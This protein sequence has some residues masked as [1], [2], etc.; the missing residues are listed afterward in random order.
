MKCSPRLSQFGEPLDMA[1][2]P[3]EVGDLRA[4]QRVM[5]RREGR[6][7][8]GRIRSLFADQLSVMVELD[9]PRAFV[10]L[11]VFDVVA[12]IAD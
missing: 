11:P 10:C 3:V 1:P 7:H 12:T 5:I 2:A 8:A 4:G 9:N 6:Q